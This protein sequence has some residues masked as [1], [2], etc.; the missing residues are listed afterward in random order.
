MMALRLVVF[1]PVPVGLPIAAPF[2][3][4]EHSHNLGRS[5]CWTGPTAQ[6]AV[7]IATDAGPDQAHN[8]AGPDGQ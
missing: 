6:A 1:G 4:V 2:L 8:R 5:D 3:R 7:G